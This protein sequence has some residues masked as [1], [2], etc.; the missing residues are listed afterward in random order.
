MVPNFLSAAWYGEAF[1]WLVVQGVENLILLDSLFPLDGGRRRE[2]KKKKMPW[3][4]RVYLGLDPPFWLCHESQL[5]GA[6][7]G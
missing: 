1:H 2:G 7:K 5:L 6:I 4:K 3:G